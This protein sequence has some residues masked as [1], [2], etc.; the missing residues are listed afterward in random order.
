M[1]QV[2]YIYDVHK[3]LCTIDL[4][5]GPPKLTSFWPAKS[6]PGGDARKTGEQDSLE[7]EEAVTLHQNFPDAAKQR[8]SRI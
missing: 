6:I 7:Q 4:G 5:R 8:L 1:R 3:L 2:G